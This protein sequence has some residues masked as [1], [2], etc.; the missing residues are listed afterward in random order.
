MPR[1]GPKEQLPPPPPETTVMPTTTTTATPATKIIWRTLRPVKVTEVIYLTQRPPRPRLTKGG[2]KGGRSSDDRRKEWKETVKQWAEGE[3]QY[4]QQEE[5]DTTKSTLLSPSATTKSTVSSTISSAT[6][7][8]KQTS[9]PKGK[10]IKEEEEA[11]KSPTEYTIPSIFLPEARR[12]R[13]SRSSSSSSRS[14]SSSSRSS[15]F[16]T[17]ATTTSITKTPTTLAPVI[18]GPYGGLWADAGSGVQS[19]S[20]GEE[21]LPLRPVGD[22]LKQISLA[23]QQQQ[24]QQQQQEEKLPGVKKALLKELILEETEIERKNQRKEEQE[25]KATD[26]NTARPSSTATPLLSYVTE[27][28]YFNVPA[29]ELRR[30]GLLGEVVGAAEAEEAAGSGSG[31][32]EKY[33]T[34]FDIIGCIN[35]LCFPGC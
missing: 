28:Q 5:E 6:G 20:D 33:D 4:Y 32:D 21:V 14:S 23:Q 7:S 9:K 3:Y 34:N 13:H 19:S 11:T 25:K 2:G 12:H 24:Q 22:W 17:T 18:V 30:S 31:G 10:K 8:S 1:K 26:K 16:A 27:W 35:T 29:E 15:S